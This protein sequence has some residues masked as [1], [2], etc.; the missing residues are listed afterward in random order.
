MSIKRQILVWMVIITAIPLIIMTLQGMHC[1][2]MA[3]MDIQR[4]NLRTVL[5]LRGQQVETV[6]HDRLA[7]LERVRQAAAVKSLLAQPEN[8]DARAAVTDLLRRLHA[9]RRHMQRLQ[10]CDA[11]GNVLAAHAAGGAPAFVTDGR[12]EEGSAHVVQDGTRA[13]AHISMPLQL[14]GR[15]R[16]GLAVVMDLSD[17][18][19]AMETGGELH[20]VCLAAGC[21]RCMVFPRT[22]RTRG[23]ADFRLPG[24]LLEAPERIRSYENFNGVR[25]LGMSQRIDVFDWVLVAE[26]E[27]AEAF[28]WVSRLGRRALIT[29]AVALVLALLLALHVSG[30]I[31]RPLQALAS[32]ATD[33]AGGRTEQRLEVEG[34]PEAREVARAFNQML[35]ELARTNRQLVQAASLAAVGEITASLAHEM[36]NPLATVKMNLA[37]LS[38]KAADDPAYGELSRLAGRQV[39]R[40][41]DMLQDLLNFGKPVPLEPAELDAAELA[42][43]VG[44]LCGE[45][46]R[47]NSVD[48]EV[49]CDAATT[50]FTGDR[51]QLRR[52][53]VNLVENAVAASPAGGTVTLRV[54]AAGDLMVFEVT[55]EGRGIA[56]HNADDIFKPFFTTREEGTGLGLAI[57]KKIVRLHEGT[58]AAA[59][60]TDAD[61]AVFTLRLPIHA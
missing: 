27:E 31:S 36:R 57:V 46:A 33:V 1:A 50:A 38:Q 58:I 59:N 11:A 21:G 42:Q 44:D 52:A 32:V 51:E 9:Q 16:G 15:V 56:A 47:T 40:L 2:R 18:P 23:K 41:E 30:R 28:R 39:E 10:V 20:H 25:V 22:E 53:L 24:A 45:S 6:M 54:T 48:V 8:A 49:V 7:A 37:A 5:D 3:I 26:V 43:E 19:L 55:D 17:L 61:G 4:E 60:R 13:T 34:A 14:Q 35:D 29:A 12:C